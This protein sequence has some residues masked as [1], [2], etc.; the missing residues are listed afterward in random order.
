[1][2]SHKIAE[3][4]VG[5]RPQCS[6]EEA[7]TATILDETFVSPALPAKSGKRTSKSHKVPLAGE[8]AQ[9]PLS[10]MQGSLDSLLSA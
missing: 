6:S 7:G 10:A 2:E 5:G 1:M 3:E 8:P 4:G 9:Q